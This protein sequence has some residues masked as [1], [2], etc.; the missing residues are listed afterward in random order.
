M[1]G[2]VDRRF[3]VDGDGDAGVLAERGEGGEAAR[4][5]DLVGDEDVVAQ[6]GGRQADG[7]SGR[8]AGE[9]GVTERRTGGRPAR[10]TCGP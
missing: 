10:C 9:R 6:P 7:L 8:G 5:D 2:G 3:A 1:G 4:V